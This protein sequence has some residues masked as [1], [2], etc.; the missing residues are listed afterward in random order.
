M[1]FYGDLFKLAGPVG[2]TTAAVFVAAVAVVLAGFVLAFTVGRRRPDG[3][4]IRTWEIIVLSV[5]AAGWVVAFGGSFLGAA[6]FL[7]GGKGSSLARI[8]L[9]AAGMAQICVCA[10]SGFVTVALALVGFAAVRL[11]LDKYK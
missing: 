5:G 2:T 10:P 8:A 6:T 3:R 4:I 9:A 11:L 7:S 1:G